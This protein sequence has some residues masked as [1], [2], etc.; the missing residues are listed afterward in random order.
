MAE[1][2]STSEPKPRTT[3]MFKY[4]VVSELH[5]RTLMNYL[6]QASSLKV[7]HVLAPII[8]MTFLRLSYSSLMY[9]LSIVSSLVLYLARERPERIL[10]LQLI[11]I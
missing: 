9:H 8:A 1:I 10:M 5:Y 11:C 2:F 7:F 4:T 3:E 6:S